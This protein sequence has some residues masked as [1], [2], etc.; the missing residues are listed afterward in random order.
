MVRYRRFGEV[1]LELGLIA[2]ADLAEAL[3][4]QAE[5][6]A[7]GDRVLLGQI[8]LETALMDETGIKRV[9]DTLYPVEEDEVE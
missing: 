8:L 9:L 4:E 1:A 5:R 6:R 2:P 3:A 7:R